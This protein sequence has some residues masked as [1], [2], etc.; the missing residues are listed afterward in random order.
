MQEAS[1]V[2]LLRAIG[3]WMYFVE[4]IVCNRAHKLLIMLLFVAKN[5]TIYTKCKIWII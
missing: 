2:K 1:T 5:L 4:G 3:V